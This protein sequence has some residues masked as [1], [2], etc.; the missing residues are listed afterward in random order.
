LISSETGV[1]DPMKDPLVKAKMK[2]T[3]KPVGQ[4]KTASSSQQAGGTKTASAEGS[5]ASTSGGGAPDGQQVYK[6]TCFACHA[7]GAAG[8][9]KINDKAAWAPRIAKGKDTLYKHAIHGFKG[10]PAKG[11]NAGLSD[12]AVK[13]AVDYIVGQPKS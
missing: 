4:V 10:M 6:S 5:S 2:E 8:A 3:L 13:A 9:P 1:N 11:G 7:T 12:A